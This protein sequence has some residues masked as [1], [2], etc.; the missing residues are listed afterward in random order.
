MSEKEIEKRKRRNKYFLHYNK[1]K[2]KK[3]ILFYTV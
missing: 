2:N 3:D 1:Y